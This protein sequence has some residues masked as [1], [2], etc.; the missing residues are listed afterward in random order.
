MIESVTRK[1]QGLALAADGWKPLAIAVRLNVSDTTVYRWLNPAYAERSRAA[2][3]RW[4]TTERCREVKRLYRAK[5]R[6]QVL[7]ST[8][9][10]DNHE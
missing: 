4:G 3:K 2:R 6:T 10:E 1:E 7:A 8:K 9:G 5:L